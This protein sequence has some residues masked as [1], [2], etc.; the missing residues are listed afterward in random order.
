MNFCAVFSV[1]IWKNGQKYGEKIFNIFFVL[2]F[3]FYILF[4]IFFQYFQMD[5]AITYVLSLPFQLRFHLGKY[6]PQTW[7]YFKIPLKIVITWHCPFEE[8][9]VCEVISSCLSCQYWRSQR[10]WDVLSSHALSWWKIFWGAF[11][12]RSSVIP[13]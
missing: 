1:V 6:L 2:L 13:L 4:D 12:N 3:F 11:K 5:V 9:F 8:C 7:W 10:S